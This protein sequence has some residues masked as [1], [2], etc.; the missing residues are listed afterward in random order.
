MPSQYTGRCAMDAP[1]STISIAGQ[2]PK[3]DDK[4]K[5]ARAKFRVLVN[6]KLVRTAKPLLE[7]FR[8]SNLPAK[9]SRQKLH[10]GHRQNYARAAPWAART[11][12]D[13][14]HFSTVPVAGT[15]ARLISGKGLPTQGWSHTTSPNWSKLSLGIEI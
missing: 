7:D 9:P 8:P 3:H 10:P 13:P 4:T 5:K 1:S 6:L 11:K 12:D 15:I 2:I 14:T